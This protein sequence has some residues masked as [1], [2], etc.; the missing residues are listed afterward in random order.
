MATSMQF[1]LHLCRRKVEMLRVRYLI[2]AAAYSLH[3][4]PIQCVSLDVLPFCKLD[5]ECEQLMYTETTVVKRYVLAS[6]ERIVFNCN[7]SQI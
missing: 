5:R 7:A 1:L 6:C 2:N 3:F 4:T